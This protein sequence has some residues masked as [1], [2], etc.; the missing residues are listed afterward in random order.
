MSFAVLDVDD[1]HDFVASDDRGREEGVVLIFGEFGEALEAGIEKGFLTD[2]NEAAFAGNPTGE[3]FVE[4]EAD[5]AEGI[6]GWV[7]GGA[8]KKIPLV[9]EVEEAGIGAHELND[10]GIDSGENLLEAEFFDHE[11]ADFL[12]KAQL[13]VSTVELE[14]EILYLR[15]S[16]I[17]AGRLR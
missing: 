17:M 2:G 15:H 3:A 11:A 12:K 1:T 5:L 9:K 8:K 7:I 14:L 6:G 13:L 4:A 16:F 10:K